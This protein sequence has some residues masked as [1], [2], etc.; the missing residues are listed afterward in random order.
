MFDILHE[1]VRLENNQLEETKHFKEKTNR[2]ILD[3]KAVEKRKKPKLDKSF[4][5]SLANDDEGVPF[6]VVTSE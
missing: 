2:K 1:L 5:L 6:K 4:D 3:F